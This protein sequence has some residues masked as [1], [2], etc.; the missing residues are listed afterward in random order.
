[1]AVPVRPPARDDPEV[2]HFGIPLEPDPTPQKL[3]A[4]PGTRSAVLVDEV[5]QIQHAACGTLETAVLRVVDPP[6]LL[7]Q[8]EAKEAPSDG[9]LTAPEMKE[10]E[11]HGCRMIAER[12]NG[13]ALDSVPG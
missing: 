12:A 2:G 10:I 8:V 3:S 1:M 5:R 4:L 9:C 11:Q 7:R 13:D 6:F